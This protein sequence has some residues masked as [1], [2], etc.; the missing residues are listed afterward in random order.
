M[1]V[2]IIVLIL[3]VLLF[4]VSF[5]T[6]RR[7]G[8]LGLALAAGAMLSETWTPG[9]TPYVHEAG[10]R[11]V[12]P[13]LESV[14]GSVLILLPAILLLFSG[15]TYHTLWQ[16]IVGSAVFA[17]LALSFLLEPLGGALVLTGDSQ[18]VYAFL[19]DNRTWIITG[20]ILYALVDLLMVKTP[21]HKEK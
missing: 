14:V 20:G 1:N 8:V 19:V 11:L 6:R 2:V 16:K 4:A 21:R 13:P 5:F 7:F 10:V 18:T 17:L 12:A 9:L 15:P 3:V